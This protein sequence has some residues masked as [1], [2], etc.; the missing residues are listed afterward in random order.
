MKR[1]F[2]ILFFLVVQGGIAKGQTCPPGPPQ[3]RYDGATLGILLPGGARQ[4]SFEY[5]KISGF[6]CFERLRAWYPAYL[7]SAN[8]I[9]P[10]HLIVDMAYA[11]H[12]SAT[13]FNIVV[14]SNGNYSVTIRYAFAFGLFPGVTDRPEG[15][16]VNGVV[17]SYDMHF[18]ITYSFEDYDCSSILVPLRAGKNTIEI[19][20]ISN[21]GIP[22]ADTITVTQAGR[23]TCLDAAP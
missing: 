10:H 19:F 6:D 16:K 5:A 3:S 21:H 22:R 14:P 12:G 13:F 2:L 15:I 23:P 8:S 17:I 7:N 9:S 4:Y 18:P 20:N 1:S 11:V